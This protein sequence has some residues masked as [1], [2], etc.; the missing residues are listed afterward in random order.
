MNSHSPTGREFSIA[1]A[2]L[3]LLTLAVFFPAVEYPFINF[4]DD[5]YVYAN[6]DVAQGLTTDSVRAAFSQFVSAH[7]HP[8]TM[9]SY[10]ADRE[11]FGP[12]AA[13]FH[14]TSL[15]LHIINAMLLAYLLYRMT[16]AAWRSML[17]A[18]IF[19]VHPLHVE[20]VVWVSS[21]KDVL[22][23]TFWFLSLLAYLWYF[24]RPT[25]R[26]YMALL[27]VFVLGLLA[28]SVL[29]T[30]PFLLLLLDYWP[31]RRFA[32]G[33]WQ[34]QQGRRRLVRL[35][36][37]KSVLF[38]PAVVVLAINSI[39]QRA[40]GNLEGMGQLSLLERLSN[41]TV[42]YATY[43]LQALV[44][45]DLAPYYPLPPEGYP[46]LTIALSAALLV[47]IT[48]VVLQH[49]PAQPYLATGWFWFLGTLAPVVGVVQLGAQAHADRYTYVPLI[50]LAIMAV[51]GLTA[52]GQLRPRRQPFLVIAGAGACAALVLVASEQVRLWREPET[53]Y[54][55]T[56]AVTEDNYLI[57]YNLAAHYGSIGRSADAE[58]E[59]RA[60][61]EALPNH[62]HS[63]VNL[64]ALLAERGES[65][66]AIEHFR[67]ALSQNPAH[68]VALANLALALVE[69]N[70][71][72]EALRKAKA[73]LQLDPTSEQARI[74]AAL[75]QEALARRE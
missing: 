44:P 51:W 22:S 39:G 34:T 24:E 73:A 32:W 43:I 47:A 12:D 4:D 36:V 59:Y 49:G 6:S 16:G 29:V 18:F 55:H 14:R 11:L 63:H 2:L 23:G 65:G 70:Q 15:A 5:V 53:L 56:L 28:K 68:P 9:L 75:A 67:A 7:W 57:H 62:L 8:L 13:A 27:A 37:E 74:A 60:A 40:S 52:Y 19:G 45:I 21:R 33:A 61:L 10:M 46:L 20:P 25:A 72:G 66:E 71:P 69:A 30:L 54:R 31:F 38:V 1:L 58:T 42:A 3:A 48:V 41:A 35:I 17:V 26:R 50:G 64:G